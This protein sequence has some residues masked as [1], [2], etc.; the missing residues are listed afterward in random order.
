[1]YEASRLWS[2]YLWIFI[3]EFGS[4]VIYI[5]TF[6]IVRKRITAFRFPGNTTHASTGRV[7]QSQ[8]SRNAR[9]NRA[10]LYMILYPAAYFVCTGPA[11]VARI[12]TMNTGKT[13]P[14][15]YLILAASLLTSAGWIDSLLYTLTRRIFV[16]SHN[17]SSSASHN[18]IRSIGGGYSNSRPLERSGTDEDLFVPRGDESNK[19]VSVPMSVYKMTTIHQSAKSGDHDPLSRID[20]AG[21][22]RSGYKVVTKAEGAVVSR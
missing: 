3:F 14:V 2:H 15:W 9:I 13:Y 17:N 22:T 11:L 6:I 5:T 7:K 21:N 16:D 12:Y 4:I 19:S 20:S 18:Y 1:M 10:T 8:N